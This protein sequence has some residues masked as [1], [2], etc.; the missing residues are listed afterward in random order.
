MAATDVVVDHVT[1]DYYVQMYAK[2]YEGLSKCSQ[3]WQRFSYKWFDRR[4][5]K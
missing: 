3:L 1:D 2:D 5:E 4:Y